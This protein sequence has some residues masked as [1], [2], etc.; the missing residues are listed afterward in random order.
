ML[1]SSTFVV[2]FLVQ[3]MCRYPACQ[4][5]F[6]ASIHFWIPFGRRTPC[7]AMYISARV[8]PKKMNRAAIGRSWFIPHIS[9]L[10]PY[11]T[12][13]LSTNFMVS[14]EGNGRE[15][16][17]VKILPSYNSGEWC[18]RV[19]IYRGPIHVYQFSP[20]SSSSFHAE[21]PNIDQLTTREIHVH[22]FICQTTP[23]S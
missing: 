12:R 10:P 4:L 11:T 18:L 16:K 19:Q 17:A 8:Q 14:Q 15:R 23:A 21:W 5:L 22:V 9:I 6:V 1:C 7:S 3:C 20:T 2:W 13:R